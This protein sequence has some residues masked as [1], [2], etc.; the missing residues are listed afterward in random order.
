MAA[1]DGRAP[2]VYRTTCSVRAEAWV[3][4]GY[5]PSATPMFILV[6][7]TSENSKFPRVPDGGRE[8][9]TRRWD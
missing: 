4:N 5:M 6:Y 7:G 8:S 1:V 2:A 9:P 3:H